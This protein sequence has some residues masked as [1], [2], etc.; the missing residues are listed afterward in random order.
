M[1]RSKENKVKLSR[2]HTAQRVAIWVFKWS[3]FLCMNIIT[4]VHFTK[5]RSYAIFHFSHLTL[6]IENISHVNK[7]FSIISKKK[8]KEQPFCLCFVDFDQDLAYH[9]TF[10]ASTYVVWIN[11]GLCGKIHSQKREFL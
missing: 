8:K 2:N 6:F 11:T 4:Y 7:Y 1:Q 9:L 5:I 3:H 10:K